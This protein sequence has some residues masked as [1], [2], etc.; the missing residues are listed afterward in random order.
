MDKTKKKFEE[1][2]SLGELIADLSE[3][4]MFV[5]ADIGYSG[6]NLEAKRKCQERY[7]ELEVTIR[8]LDRIYE[9]ATQELIDTD[10]VYYLKYRLEE[11]ISDVECSIVYHGRN[12]ANEKLLK[13]L[14]SVSETI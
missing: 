5:G 12:E 9:E 2:L 10:N 4:Q 13:A 3:E 11:I 6:D 8:V 1:W 14:R 7:D